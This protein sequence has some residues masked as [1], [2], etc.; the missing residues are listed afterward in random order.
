M[1]PKSGVKRK[2]VTTKDYMKL[3]M[4]C[5]EEKLESHTESILCNSEMKLVDINDLARM[6]DSRE[7]KKRR[8]E[9]E[10]TYKKYYLFG[11]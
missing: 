8:E 5:Q 6:R 2:Y 7:K 4:D 1:K 3:Y 11:V 9:M 10:K